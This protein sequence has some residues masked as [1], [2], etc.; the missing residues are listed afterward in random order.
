MI[1]FLIKK[2]S[3]NSAI[4][5]SK[6]EIDSDVEHE[7]LVLNLIADAIKELN[8]IL[9]DRASEF[10]IIMSG[11]RGVFKVGESEF[12]V[13]ND[14]MGGTTLVSKNAELIQK[15]KEIMERSVTQI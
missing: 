6:D 11:D 14:S 8:A 3:E 2:V 10:E 1:K 12:T 13:I 7:K 5:F 4:I 15:I 9:L